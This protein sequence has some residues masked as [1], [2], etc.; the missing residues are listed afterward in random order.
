MAGGDGAPGRLL[1][2][3]C[4]CGLLDAWQDAFLRREKRVCV[5]TEACS[6]GVSLHAGPGDPQ[7]VHIMAELSEVGRVWVGAI[8]SHTDPPEMVVVS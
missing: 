7:R 5:I 8:V 4:V 3:D 1:T 2:S 6:T